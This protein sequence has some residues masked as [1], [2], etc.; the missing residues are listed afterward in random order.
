M[1]GCNPEPIVDMAVFTDSLTNRIGWVGEATLPPGGVA[2]IVIA[3]WTAAELGSADP[4]TKI[5]DPH[6]NA[7]AVC[8]IEQILP[9]ASMATIPSLFIGIGGRGLGIFSGT[10]Q[11]SFSLTCVCH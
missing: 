8:T 3:G 10:N 11:N 4:S 9:S 5:P 6:G 7:F 1:Y 2:R